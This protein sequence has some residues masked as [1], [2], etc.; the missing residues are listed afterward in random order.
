MIGKLSVPHKHLIKD[1]MRP[2]Q[3]VQHDAIVNPLL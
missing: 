2:D 3:S 1:L